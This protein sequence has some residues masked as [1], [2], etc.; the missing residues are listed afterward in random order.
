MIFTVSLHWRKPISLSFL[1]TISCKWFLVK[2]WESVPNFSSP[3]WEFICLEL[4]MFI[5]ALV[6]SVNSYV[7]LYCFWKMSFTW[8]FYS[9]SDVL[10]PLLTP[11]LQRSLSLEQRVISAFSLWLSVLK[12]L[13]LSH[14]QLLVSVLI[15]M[16]FKKKSL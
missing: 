16:S 13:T 3:C 5:H 12:T 8:S 15:T 7:Y 4:C 2:L 14:F 10:N 1:A 11:L 6:V 9:T